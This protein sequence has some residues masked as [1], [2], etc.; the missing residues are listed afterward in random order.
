MKRLVG[1]FVFVSLLATAVTAGAA[2]KRAL[3]RFS[4]SSGWDGLPA[5]VAIERGFFAQEGLVV[6]GM[7]VSS[8]A[9]V[10]G[11][12]AARSTDFATV[13]QRTLLVMVAAKLPIK[14]VAMSGY[15]VPMDLVVPVADKKTKS[16]ADLKGKTIAVGRGSEAHPVL[17]RLLNAARMRPNDVKIRLMSAL[18][19]TNAFKQ[20]RASAVFETRHYT[21][22]LVASKQARVVMPDGQVNKVLGRIG[23][24]PLVVNRETLSRE[25]ATVQRFVN[26]WIKALIYIGQNPKDATSL[27]QIYFHRQGVKTTP[28][29]AKFWV[30]LTRYDRFVWNN[31]AI[32]DAEYNGW[33]LKTGGILKVAPKLDGYVD[34]RFAL[35][36]VNALRKK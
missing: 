31:N 8:P 29:L 35:K 28:Q 7:P 20:K 6:S 5:I 34:N 19:L 11:S 13:P 33:G 30:G 32:K 23:A 17:V 3:L 9:A 10:M 27:L 21:A 22:T 36:A 24:A 14:I 4:F 12:L 1:V 18:Q 15:G 16:L 2:E 26:A 25:P